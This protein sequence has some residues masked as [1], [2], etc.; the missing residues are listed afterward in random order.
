MMWSRPAPV[1]SLAL[2][3]LAGSAA[4]LIA[5]SIPTGSGAPRA[6]LYGLSV[7]A[8]LC[9]VLVYLVGERMP[10]LG[11][12]LLLVFSALGV[13]V[14]VAHAATSTGIMVAGFVYL[15]VVIFAANFGGQRR[16]FAHAVADSAMYGVALWF[17]GLPGAPAT[18]IVVS[19]ALF[20]VA[21]SVGRV[22]DRLH[23]QVSTDVLTG[24]LSRA[25]LVAAATRAIQ[26]AHRSGQPLSM[27]LLDLDD[28]KAVNDTLGHAE[29]DRVLKAVSESWRAQLRAGDKLAR[30]GGDEFVV[31]LPGTAGMAACGVAERL[32][33]A[34]GFACSAGVSEM[35]PG[36]DLDVL[37]ARAD[38]DMYRAK[39]VRDMYRANAV[40]DVDRGEPLA[41]PA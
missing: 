19:L 28:F 26:V 23:E 38:K 9:A 35:K 33:T 20:A 29:G 36:D 18:W 1:W 16:A 39:A 14:F 41:E 15:I 27:V 40:S 13:S 12:D 8:V 30:M 2:L 6:V 21:E 25:G 10:R 5:A 11:I 17:C 4:G 22:V 24:V 37:L 32:S 3:Y 7:K 34:A 31:V